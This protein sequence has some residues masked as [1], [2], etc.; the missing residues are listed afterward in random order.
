[1]AG[2]IEQ[3]ANSTMEGA[4][5]AIGGGIVGG[6]MN[7]LD[8][9][10]FGDKR[11]KQQIKQQQK[12]TDIQTAAN[13]ELADYGMG[14]SKEMFEYTG[15]GAQRR[16]MEEAG[17]NPALMYGH[18]GAGGT[19]TSASAGQAS[20]SQASNETQRKEADMQAIGMGLQMQKQMAE[21]RLLNAQAKEHEA[22]A[23][24]KSEQKTTEANK[25][26]ILIE[27]LKQEGIGDWIQNIEKLYL[28]NPYK[29]NEI[30]LFRNVTYNT[31]TAIQGQSLF[32]REVTNAILKTEAETGNEI[33]Q[34]ALSNEKAKIV[35]QEL[36]VA[37]QNA[38]ANTTRAK[39]IEL[40]AMWDTGEMTNWKTWVDTGAKAIN[41]ISNIIPKKI[42]KK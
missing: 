36:L 17:L 37:M 22:G 26:D 19:T 1:M 32:T 10:L 15:Y 11:R 7:W 27:N 38:D 5:N 23:G 40:A 9:A 6:A 28:H 33:A 3:L 12:L 16:Q 34:A 18:A 35:Y 24:L 21:I 42:I 29:D 30:Q 4:G 25:R 31:N 39:A 14:I 13:K 20:G 2:M 41:S 8:E